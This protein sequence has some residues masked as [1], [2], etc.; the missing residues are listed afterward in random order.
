MLLF[1]TLEVLAAF[2]IN[3]LVNMLAIKSG[4]RVLLRINKF[5]DNVRN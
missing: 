2:L 3:N 4:T 1:Q 5:N